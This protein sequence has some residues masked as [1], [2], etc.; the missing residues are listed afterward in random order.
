MSRL[1]SRSSSRSLSVGPPFERFGC[2]I[3]RAYS[4]QRLNE[5]M[6][7]EY[8]SKSVDPSMLGRRRSF[9]DPNNYGQYDYLRG[10]NRRSS[11]MGP[12]DRHSAFFDRYSE[13]STGSHRNHHA[14][15]STN[16]PII[17]G[18]YHH[19]RPYYWY[20]TAPRVVSY[21][22]PY[23]DWRYTPRYPSRTPSLY[24]SHYKT[25]DSYVWRL[26][27][28]LTSVRS[29]QSSARDLTYLKAMRGLCMGKYLY[30]EPAGPLCPTAIY[31]HRQPYPI[32]QYA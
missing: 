22:Y 18:Y 27:G 8:R 5:T 9:G 23:S 17:D 20:H 24:S 21:F 26:H 15:S 11:T 12:L 2:G 4:T 7:G 32:N 29:L 13:L 19:F 3:S 14:M 25:D 31:S 16:R 6:R 1:W 30:D 28:A 10:R